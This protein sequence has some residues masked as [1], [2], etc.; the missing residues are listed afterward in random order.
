MT[1]NTCKLPYAGMLTI[2]EQTLMTSEDGQW[3]LAKEEISRGN[4]TQK[5]TTNHREL[6]KIF[7]DHNVI[8][9]LEIELKICLQS[10]QMQ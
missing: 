2:S 3:G 6:N 10:L 4:I 5:C 7:T 8:M 1:A 9:V